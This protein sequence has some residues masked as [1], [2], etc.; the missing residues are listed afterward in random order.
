MKTTQVN[1]LI[2]IRLF[3]DEVII[4]CLVEA[5]KKYQ[6]QTAIVL[7]AVG[8]LKQSTIGYFKEKGNYASE[9]F[10]KSHELLHLSGT[11]ISYKDTYYP[12]LHVILGNEHKQ[13]I[14][15][16][17][18]SGIVEITNEIVLMTSQS[19]LERKHSLETGLNE[20]IIPD[21]T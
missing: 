17:L 12:H 3:S 21:E 10:Q 19:K 20:L 5:C 14:G 7:S 18:I 16:H 6:I 2:F 9:I 15:G 4:N 11:I 8:Q 1:N 13:V